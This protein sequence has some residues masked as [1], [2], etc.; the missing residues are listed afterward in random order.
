MAYQ[1]TLTELT[2]MVRLYL[3]E[4]TAAFY[5]ATGL[6]SYINQGKDR[7]VT[8]VRRLKDDYF[9]RTLTSTDG[10]VTCHGESYAT[11]SFAIVA[12]TRDYTLP[13][14]Y[15]SMK[16]I[17]V[18]TSGYETVTFVYRD[19]AHPDMRSAMTQTEYQSPATFYFSILGERT[20]RIAPK[21][22]AA[23]DLRLT[24]EQTFADLSSGSDSL[25]M[26]H[27]LYLAV[28]H[29][30]TASALLQD[31][32]A[33]SAAHEARA[34]QII[35]DFIGGNSRQ[36]QDVQTATAYGAGDWC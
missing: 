3:D 31:R 11:S 29:F 35:D 13:H 33:D 5:S 1:K 15:G 28:V 30:A 14:D 36:M 17:E 6:T 10:S 20:M 19:L 4:P 22:S 9:L 23:L 24:Y 7:V 2:T 26:P 32:A 8:I 21:S 34:K 16:T 25:T 27:P 18:V 12:G